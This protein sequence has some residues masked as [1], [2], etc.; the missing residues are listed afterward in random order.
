L[1]LFLTLVAMQAPAF[2]ADY[3]ASLLQV[4]GDA[5]RDIDQREA[6]ARQYYSLPKGDDAALIAGLTPHEPANAQTL[7]LSVDR[8][9]TLQASRERILSGPSLLQ[10]LIALV[11]AARDPAG[12]KAAI[13]R[14][15]LQTYVVHL[16]L[17]VAAMIYG[18]AGIL[19]G[20]LL[21]HL[22]CV[23]FERA[24]DE[25]RLAKI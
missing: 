2:T 1:A 7:A 8:A 17:T 11:D 12:Y 4:S 23:P 25:R 10:P 6:A 9:A 3:T 18:L 20:S 5:R 24:G 13:W 19:L 16:D 22:V 14:T 15:Q 21:G